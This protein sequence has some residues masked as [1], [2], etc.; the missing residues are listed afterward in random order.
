MHISRHIS[1]LWKVNTR[2][3]GRTYRATMGGFV[4]I[5]PRISTYVSRTTLKLISYSP[6]ANPIILNDM[7]DINLRG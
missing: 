7:W 4:Y 5:P 6:D 3:Y 1:R 2:R